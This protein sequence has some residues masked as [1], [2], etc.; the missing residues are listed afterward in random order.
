METT[1]VI[2][3]VP[4]PA[5]ETPLVI[6]QPQPE[7]T[8]PIGGVALFGKEAA[9]AQFENLTKNYLP[10]TLGRTAIFKA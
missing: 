4:L 8:R 9:V 2:Q 10:N 3:Q 7:F 1:Q 5:L 6:N